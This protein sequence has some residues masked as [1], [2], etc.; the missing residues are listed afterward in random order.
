MVLWFVSLCVHRLSSWYAVF[1]FPTLWVSY[2]Y[3]FILLLAKGDITGLPIFSQVQFPPTVQIVSITGLLGL[4]FL[5]IL[6][7]S[8][9]ILSWYYRKTHQKQAVLSLFSTLSIIVVALA[10]GITSL[11]QNDSLPKLKVGL[12]A[13]SVLD[14]HSF[15]TER[16][17]DP[18]AQAHA[19]ADTV[20]RLA[21][22][23]AEYILQ[24]EKTLWVTP[25]DQREIFQILSHS[26]QENKVYVFAPLALVHRLPQ[27]NALYVFAPNGNLVAAYN[28]MH[29]VS[30]FESAFIPGNSLSTIPLPT[31]LIGLEI[32][33]D[34]DFLKPTKNYSQKGIGLL[35]VPAEDFGV[36]TDGK[37]HAQVAIVQSIVGGFSLARSAYFGFLSATD[38]H[39]RILS[40]QPT[41]PGKEITAIVDVPIASGHTFY[42]RT[43]DWFPWLNCMGTLIFLGL[44]IKSCK[45][46][47]IHL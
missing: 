22:N 23:G 7:P 38:P 42:S 17:K 30:G 26:A 39:G 18:I 1:V 13:K 11:Q 14:F 4:S 2:L 40:W 44:I 47:D 24:P 37:W 3:L 34:M 36:Q 29:L 45:N 21:E 33:H 8:G 5:T 27:R 35:F 32:C 9:L 31:G 43:G 25:D 20:H 6:L 15:L 28:K 41:V 46:E 19:F 10:F 12:A 16:N